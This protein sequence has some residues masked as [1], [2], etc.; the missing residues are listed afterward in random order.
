LAVDVGGMFWERD[1][2]T[3]PVID[4]HFAA[5]DGGT[6]LPSSSAAVVVH[7]TERIH[8]RFRNIDDFVWLV[9]HER[10]DFDAFCAMFLARRIVEGRLPHRGWEKIGIHPDGWVPVVG[11]GGIDWFDWD[12]GEATPEQRLAV[13]LSSVASH[14]DN[15]VALKCPPTIALRS[16]L[17]A[18]LS[19]GRDYANE[20]SGATEFFEEVEHVMGHGESPLN[21]LFDP[22]LGDR[23]GICLVKHQLNI[24]TPRSA[25]FGSAE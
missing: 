7:S 12:L 8:R 10:P 11:R 1:G 13:L 2:N 20:Y 19:R 16:V 3:L 4:H 15:C 9:A 21:P 17:H 25:Y 5:R 22:V 18:A 23:S 14:A 6:P 24:L